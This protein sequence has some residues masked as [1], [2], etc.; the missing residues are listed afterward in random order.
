[1]CARW[2]WEVCVCRGEVGG[3]TWS[4]GVSVVCGCDACG[5]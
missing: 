5:V 3:W 1:M 2:G 4:E